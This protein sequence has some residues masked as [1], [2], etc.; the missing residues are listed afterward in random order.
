M[1]PV[2]MEATQNG[3]VRHEA[4]AGR[5]RGAAGHKGTKNL[6]SHLGRSD[7]RA[8]ERASAHLRN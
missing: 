4:S 8:S 5:S 2:D 3:D 1:T 7:E 6:A